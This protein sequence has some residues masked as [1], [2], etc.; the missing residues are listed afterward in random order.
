M[1]LNERKAGYKYRVFLTTKLNGQVERFSKKLEVRLRHY[2]REHQ[3][4][5]DNYVQPLTFSNK[6]QVGH[7]AKA[8]SL[9]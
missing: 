1:C 2:I 3:T 7:T 4:G 6:I 8:S 9:A 5:C